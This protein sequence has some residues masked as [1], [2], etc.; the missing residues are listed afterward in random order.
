MSEE[1]KKLYEDFKNEKDHFIK[2]NILHKLSKE[3]DIK[4]A[5]ISKNVNLSPSYIS[6]IMRLKKLPDLIIDGYYSNLISITHLYIISR[7][8]NPKEMIEVYE[9]VLTKNLTT[10]DTE[11]IVRQ[12]LYGIKAEGAYMLDD[13]KRQISDKLKNLLGGEVKIIQSRIKSKLLV[14]IKGNL[15]ET[16]EKLKKLMDFLN[17]P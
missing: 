17:K 13:E 9:V 16:T 8:L 14:E 1:I 5:E 3:L 4:L 11:Y 12:K 10:I 7:L 15:K 6:H 2:S